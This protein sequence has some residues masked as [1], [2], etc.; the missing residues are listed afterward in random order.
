MLEPN[1][2]TVA[3][4]GPDNRT[5]RNRDESTQFFA[6]LVNGIQESVIRID[7]VGRESWLEVDADEVEL[8]HA[9][10]YLRN[11][12]LGV[13]DDLNAAER[14]QPIRVLL[15]DLDDVLVLDEAPWCDRLAT[16]QDAHVCAGCIHLLNEKGHRALQ[17]RRSRAVSLTGDVLLRADFEDSKIQVPTK[18]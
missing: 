12:L 6:L 5:R 18:R 16:Q 17:E 14:D 11:H 10:L 13:A 1:R 2:V 3:D 7:R 4:I 9:L 8:S 15:D